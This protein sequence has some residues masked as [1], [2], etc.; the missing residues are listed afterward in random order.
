MAM[1]INSNIQSLNAQ[2]H[3][4]TS[5]ED[6]NRATER[7]SSGKRINSAADDA[8][9]LAIAN[10]MTSQVEGL[11]QAIRNA[12]DGISLIQTAEGGLQE[13]TSI[14]QRMREL[15]IQSANGIYDG[16]NRDTLNAEVSQLKEELNRI[17]K[18]TGFNGLSI[19]DGSL[20]EVSL[21][22]GENSN[23]T[24]GL[25]ISSLNTNKLG[26]DG[27]DLVGMALTAGLETFTG[28]TQEL[29]INGD[30]ITTLTAAAN[31]AE[32]LKALNDQVAGIE[33]SSF[34][35]VVG[36]STAAGGNGALQGADRLT[37]T[38]A[39]ADSTG[40][41]VFSIANTSSLQEVADKI[42]EQGGGTV[43][44]SL[45]DDGK[46]VISAGENAA[47]IT[48]G[49]AG[50]GLTKTGLATGQ[51]NASLKFTVTDSSIE[52]INIAQGTA[53]ATAGVL[54][55]NRQENGAVM[56][57]LETTAA[58]ALD[59][60]QL[61]IN[62]VSI[63][64]GDGTGTDI[65]QN[66]R[67]INEKTSETGVVAFETTVGSAQYLSLR[68]VDGGSI[69]IESGS[70]ATGANKSNKDADVLADIGFNVSNEADSARNTVANIDIST[71]A[72]AQ[73]AIDIT[74]EALK[75]IDEN[76]GELGAVSNRL[77]HTVSNLRNV[78]ENAASARSQI[79]DSDFAEESANLSRAQVL[80]QAG[81][82]M[83]AQANSRPQQVL[84]LLQ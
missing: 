43:S 19:L 6:Q 56:S 67:A 22:V 82:A 13:A 40:N 66:I 49:G 26:A 38:V 32:A 78:A 62:G 27:A 48:I 60:D 47:S 8:A 21:Q 51:T 55:L 74:T 17:G 16:G 24:V 59:A 76:R 71:A 35:E 30:D 12:N 2:R 79:M 46:L 34:V 44:A 84:S 3:L 83:L 23:Q 37:I 5:L 1:V 50:A 20:G 18:D 39:S 14:L 65:E 81:N 31:H 68:S 72:G 63:G 80:Q 33:V 7:L 9:G 25:N 10:R 53:V 4:A 36:D 52:N 45:N 70:G 15:S 42:T 28:T 75:Q 77:S 61:V 57:N 11:N 29:T 64:A 58:T 41:N 69:Q 54:G 73:K